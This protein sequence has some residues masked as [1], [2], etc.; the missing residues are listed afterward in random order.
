[1]N[2]KSITIYSDSSDSDNESDN[3]I[4]NNEN[5]SEDFI[6]LNFTQ[7]KYYNNNNYVFIKNYIKKNRHQI[8]ELLY[9]NKIIKN[10]N[11]PFKLL[12]H[13]YINYLNDDLELSFL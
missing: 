11:L 13:I 9:N 5:I 2:N 12:F 8:I 6:E 4:E 7:N 10:K 1:M 3:N